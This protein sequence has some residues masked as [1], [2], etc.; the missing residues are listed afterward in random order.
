MPNIPDLRPFYEVREDRVHCI[1]CCAQKKSTSFSRST[2][3]TSNWRRHLLMKHLGLWVEAC[4]RLKVKITADKAE[5]PVAAYRESKGQDP[6]QNSSLP[7]GF[8]EVP[9]F[10][11]EAFIDALVAFIVSNDQVGF[12]C[13]T[14]IAALM[15]IIV[16]QCC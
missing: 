2:T 5:G 15:M 3:S 11:L 10:S 8:D 12:L 7:S 6:K 16:F 1:F 9:G 4:D 13:V 14:Q